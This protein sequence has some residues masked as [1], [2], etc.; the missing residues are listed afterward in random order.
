MMSR[1]INS[2]RSYDRMVDLERELTVEIGQD[3]NAFVSLPDC[4]YSERLLR[5]DQT[6]LAIRDFNEEN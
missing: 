1:F 6:E 2:D 4:Y 5:P 3:G